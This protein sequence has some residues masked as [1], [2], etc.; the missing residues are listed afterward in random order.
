MTTF[1]GTLPHLVLGLSLDGVGQFVGY[2]I[3]AG[4]TMDRIASLELRRVDHIT[5]AD[6]DALFRPNPLQAKLGS[7]A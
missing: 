2:A 5:D 3:G 7:D 4:D 6:R 1:L